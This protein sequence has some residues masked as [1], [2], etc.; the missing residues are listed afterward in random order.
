[1]K[2]ND[3]NE[4]LASDH[5]RR[6]KDDQ[7]LLERLEFEQLISALSTRFVK[8]SPDKID[9]EIERSLKQIYEFFGCDRSALLEGTPDKTQWK[10]T[11]VAAREN[12][13]PV[14]VGEKIPAAAS[15]WVFE[16]LTQKHEIVAIS[17]LDDLPAEADAD[18]QVLMQ[19]GI[20]S[21]LSVPIIIDRKSVV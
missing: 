6:R 17:N 11:H 16:K 9:E 4:H 13:P 7:K 5:L 14:P 19:W 8:I 2:N 21:N 20:R 1:M 10:I 12:L 18:R 15:P 3:I